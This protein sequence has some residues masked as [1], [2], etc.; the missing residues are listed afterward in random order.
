MFSL[1]P[2]GSCLSPHAWQ[3]C[4]P[5]FLCAVFW[6]Y[7]PLARPPAYPLVASYD[8]HV[9]RWVMYSILPAPHGT[10][11]L[12]GRWRGLCSQFFCGITLNRW[13][14]CQSSRTRLE[15]SPDPSA[16]GLGTSLAELSA[17]EAK[18]FSSGVYRP[19]SVVPVGLWQD[20]AR[21]G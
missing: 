12:K 9:K 16:S 10:R 11:S 14:W 15:E 8:T 17:D 21:P 19:K 1:L 4:W 18:K 6:G 3:V 2:C 20:T 5:Q 13:D 7:L